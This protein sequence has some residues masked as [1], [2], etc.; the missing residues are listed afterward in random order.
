[1]ITA[2]ATG[3]DGTKIILMGL[4]KGNL[5]HLRAGRPLDAGAETHPGFPEDVRI[6]IF[7]KETEEEL[8]KI[9][10]ELMGENTKLILV[11]NN[12]G[13]HH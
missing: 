5:F 9:V 7:Y 2:V 6:C 1:M 4:T 13:S 10:S 3:K 12:N 8:M 11:D